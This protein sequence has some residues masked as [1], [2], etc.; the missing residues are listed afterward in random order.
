VEHRA[1]LCEATEPKERAHDGALVGWRDT[2]LEVLVAVEMLAQALE[3]VVAPR[4]ALVV[5]HD[6]SAFRAPGGA[7]VSLER[8]RPLRR[9]LV[10]IARARTDRPGE[11]LGQPELV[12]AGWPGE[13][14]TPRV[15]QNRLHVALDALRKSGLAGMLER[16]EGGWRLSPGVSVAWAERF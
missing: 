4:E 16:R 11:P 15:A 10:A 7:K 14:L 1:R 9:L 12:A 13:R 8:R 5:A 6:G 3:A 2:S